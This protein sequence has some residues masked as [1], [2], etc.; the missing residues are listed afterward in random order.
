MLTPDTE[1]TGDLLRTLRESQGVRLGDMV[2]RTKISRAYLQAIEEE[3][4][5]SLPAA[6]YVRGFITEYAKYLE[7]DPEQ[8]TRTFLLRS[9]TSV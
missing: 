3:D 6:V 2:K 4:W 5:S 1:F 9:P 8:A 7:L